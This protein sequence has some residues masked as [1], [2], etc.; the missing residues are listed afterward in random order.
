MNFQ[1]IWRIRLK[2]RAS[3]AGTKFSGLTPEE[4]KIVEEVID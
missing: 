1:S 4:I 2:R 3:S